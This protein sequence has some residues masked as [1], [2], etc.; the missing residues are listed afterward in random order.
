MAML[1]D[2]AQ[3]HIASIVADLEGEDDFMP[4]MTIQPRDGEGLV[5]AGLMMPEAGHEKDGLAD[6]MMGMCMVHRAVGAV[7]ANMSWMVSRSLDEGPLKD[8]EPRPSEHPD[9]VEVVFLV[10]VTP[11]GSQAYRAEIFRADNKVSLGEWED[12]QVR[13]GRF[14]DAIRMGMRL[15]AQINGGMAAYC[16]QEIEAGRGEQLIKTVLRALNSAR[17]EAAARREADAGER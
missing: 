6:I 1:V 8:D 16:D 10:H 4:F 13:G 9:R 7:H 11:D 2:R 12:V 5:Y 3:E 17:K 15:G 14:A